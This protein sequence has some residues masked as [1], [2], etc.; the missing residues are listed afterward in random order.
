MMKTCRF[1]TALPTRCDCSFLQ[2]AGNLSQHTRVRCSG[3]DSCLN[4]AP[5]CLSKNT[6][7]GWNR[8]S[9][10]CT[11]YDDRCRCDGRHG[12]ALGSD[13]CRAEHR[14]ALATLAVLFVQMYCVQADG[15]TNRWESQVRK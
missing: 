9:V 3:V 7:C 11:G 10:F 5:R 4:D 13:T 15:S 12:Q 6:V 1:P 2:C 8:N 14:W